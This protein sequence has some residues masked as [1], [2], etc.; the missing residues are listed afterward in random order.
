MSGREVYGLALVS[1]GPVLVGYA[2]LGPGGVRHFY[3]SLEEARYF[4]GFNGRIEPVYTLP[5]YLTPGGSSLA[6][7]LRWF[8]AGAVSAALVCLAA[9]AFGGPL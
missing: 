8:L 6:A 9:L 3:A 4:V 5:D 7:R 1:S 2:V